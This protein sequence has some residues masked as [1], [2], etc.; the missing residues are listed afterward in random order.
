MN[1]KK[2]TFLFIFAMLAMFLTSCSHNGF[3][4]GQGRVVV[5]NEAGFQYV[6][7]FFAYDLSREN[8]EIETETSDANGLAPAPGSSQIKGGIRIRRRIGK[9]VT[10]YLVDLAD[11]SP[12]A[13]IEYLKQTELQPLDPM[14]APTLTTEA[15][16]TLAPAKAKDDCS[17]G[18]C[19]PLNAEGAE[20]EEREALMSLM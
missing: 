8:S 15:V 4:V 11:R 20:E 18:S 1:L 9:Q 2:L 17:D 16:G 12:E 13:V 19:D 5:L 14:P 6:N 10:G 7:G 3:M